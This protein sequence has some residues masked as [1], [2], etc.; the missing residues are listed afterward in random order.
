MGFGMQ[1]CNLAD[2]GMDPLGIFQTGTARRL[3]IS[4]GGA[5]ILI[6]IFFI[7]VSDRVNSDGCGHC[8]QHSCG[9]REDGV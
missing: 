3:G 5:N 1:L 7:A 2:L 8:G 6:C 4:F 9:L